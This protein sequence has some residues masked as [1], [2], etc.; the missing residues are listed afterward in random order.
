MSTTS[1]VRTVRSADGTTIAY[2]TTG[3]GPDLLIVPGALSDAADFTGLAEALAG[4]FTVHT[5][6]R[7]GRRG[8]GPLGPGYGM[9]VECADLAAVRAA[10]GA[11]YVFGHSFGGLVALE[12]A[13]RDRHI[14][15]LAVY[16]PGVSVDGLI[17]TDW[18][19]PARRFLAQGRPIDAFAAFSTATGPRAARR[20][21]RWL[22]A[23][24]LRLAFRGEK[25]AK[26]VELLE[27]ALREHAEVGR[28][29]GS[30]PHYRTVSADVLLMT[31]GRSDLAHVG[32]ATTRLAE[33]LPSSRVHT[34]PK[35]DHFGPHHRGEAEVAA[36]LTTFLLET[37][38]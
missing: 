4:S 30:Y 36:A 6:Q 28:L 8:S 34:F 29:D 21:P 20:N 31:G 38:T 1:A 11:R 24:I 27:P 33:V 5:V 16:E 23:A 35:L 18:I 10:T 14:A 26:V 32:P 37:G 19:P 13:R 17:P 2:H 9:E 15:K 3:A 7:R 22:M 25:R 12:A